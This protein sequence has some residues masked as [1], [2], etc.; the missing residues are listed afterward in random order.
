MFSL[1]I[2]LT[3]ASNLT[4]QM[5]SLSLDYNLYTH[6]KLCISL[7]ALF[8]LLC[9]NLLEIVVKTSYEYKYEYLFFIDKSITS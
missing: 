2:I 1:I 6:A 4:S 5:V 7:P 9:L 3:S 8:V